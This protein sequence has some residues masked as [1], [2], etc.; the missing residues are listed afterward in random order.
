MTLGRFRQ[1][2]AGTVSRNSIGP[3]ADRARRKVH[4][5]LPFSELRG[6]KAVNV[7]ILIQWKHSFIVPGD[8]W[9][10]LEIWWVATVTHPNYIPVKPVRSVNP[11]L[12]P[13]EFQNS[14]GD[15]ARL[16]SDLSRPIHVVFQH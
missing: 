11:R 6:D 12:F 3:C 16:L 15:F 5:A 13:S 10:V 4:C 2:F 8:I 1:D 14:F 9:L 7:L